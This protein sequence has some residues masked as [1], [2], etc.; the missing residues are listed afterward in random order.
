MIIFGKMKSIDKPVI[1]L[2]DKEP[3]ASGGNR[4]CFRHP[5]NP[6]H[7]LKVIRS[8][9]TPAIRKAE[10]RFPA[11]LR[12][13]STYDENLVEIAA[14]NY[15]RRNYPIQI[16]RH[17]PCSFGLVET[18]LGTAHETE[19]V[20][21]ADRRISQTL[22]QYIWKNGID[23]TIERAIRTF[24]EDW[25]T[26]PPRTRDLIPH[27]FVVRLDKKNVRLV[28]ID[29]FGKKPLIQFPFVDRLAKLHLKRRLEDFDYR[30]KLIVK[31]KKEGTGP[32]HRIDNLKRE[33]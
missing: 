15:L 4:L 11:N 13:L 1:I 27:N 32:M 3:F 7:C 18:D 33:G 12:P 14:L 25:C 29:G 5:Q 17:L 23:P 10:K 31:R 6:E 26:Q 16:T 22:E 20:C 30:I 9:R 8:D 24:K 21:D 2:K 28:L 19:L